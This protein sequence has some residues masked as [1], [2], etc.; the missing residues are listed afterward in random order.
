MVG[1]ET[2]MAATS[3]HTCK[4]AF[5]S[6]LASRLIVFL[7]W[8]GEWGAKGRGLISNCAGI[9]YINAFW[10]GLHFQLWEELEMS[11]IGNESSV[12]RQES[13]WR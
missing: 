13:G 7:L 1:V 10:V 11:A 8:G 4:C 5:S 3:V 6:L 9:G 2:P 12:R